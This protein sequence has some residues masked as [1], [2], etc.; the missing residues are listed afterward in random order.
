MFWTCQYSVRPYFQEYTHPPWSYYTGQV[1]HHLLC[2]WLH[3]APH[4]SP[5]FYC[6][7]LMLSFQHSIQSVWGNLFPWTRGWC[8]IFLRVRA[9]G[10]TWRHDPVSWAPSLKPLLQSSVSLIFILWFVPSK[11]VSLASLHIRKPKHTP[12]SLGCLSSWKSLSCFLYLLE[13]SA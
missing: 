6:Y 10:C 9:E 4:G 7:S 1:Q 11:V 12:S 13:I 5:S 8:L 2:G 3:C